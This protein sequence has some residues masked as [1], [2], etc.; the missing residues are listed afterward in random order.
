MR[1]TA[2]RTS[3]WRRSSRSRRTPPP[4]RSTTTSSSSGRATSSTGGRTSSRSQTQAGCVADDRG[5]KGV[6][7]SAPAPGSAKVS[8]AGLA[9]HYGG[10]H[11]LDDVGFDV[12]AGTIHAVIGENGAGKSTLMKILAGAVRPDAGEVTLDGEPFDAHSPRQAHERGIGIVYQELSLFGE[13]PVLANLFPNN[14]ATRLGIVSWSE[15]ARRG[16][17]VLRG[18]GLD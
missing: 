11:A 18:V 5:P 1:I 7:A 15:M 8:I 4:R 14:E 6:G 12:A 10:V 17:P 9:K 3:R 16:A 2:C 13:R